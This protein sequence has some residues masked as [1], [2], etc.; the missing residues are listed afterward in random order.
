MQRID[1]A[2]LLLDEAEDSQ[3]HDMVL[4]AGPAR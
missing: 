1:L 2:N 3:H 4:G